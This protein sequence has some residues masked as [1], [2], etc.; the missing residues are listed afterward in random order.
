M[1]TPAG[2]IPALVTPLDRNGE[3]QESGLRDVLDYVIEGGVH[4]VF[5]LGSS[6]E[7]YALNSTQKRRVV[8]ITVEHVAGRV[9]VYAGASEITT[10]DCIAT[11]QMVNDIGGVSALSVLTPYFVTPTQAELIRH[12]RA[13]AASTELPVILYTNPGRTQVNL[14]PETVFELAEIDNIVGIKDS[15]GD[16]QLLERFITDRPNGFSVLVGRDTLI[17]EGL[18]NGADGAIAST[19]NVAPA[20]VAGIYEA[21]RAGDITRASELQAKLTPLRSLV[22]KATFPIIL[23]A[24]LRRAGIDAGLC[25]APAWDLDSEIEQ[26]LNIVVDEALRATKG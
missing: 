2:V 19:A 15:S 6:G 4:G 10:R 17:L 11:A 12:Y 25:A 20:L 14:E 22:D 8:E 9:P 7:I 26:E 21:F 3:I 5:V 23:K 24:G 1:F 13:I 16:R 18:R